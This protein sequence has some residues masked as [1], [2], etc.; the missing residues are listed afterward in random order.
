MIALKSKQTEISEQLDSI[1]IFP[2]S[3]STEVKNYNQPTF[4]SETKPFLME[5]T[6]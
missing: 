6:E 1:T 4:I 3:M 2:D 5:K